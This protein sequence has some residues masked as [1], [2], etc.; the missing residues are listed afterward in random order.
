MHDLRVKPEDASNPRDQQECATGQS[1]EESVL[2]GL[3]GKFSVGIG[4]LP[5]LATRLACT[6]GG[7]VAGTDEQSPPQCAMKEPGSVQWVTHMKYGR[8]S[9]VV[10]W[11]GAHSWSCILGSHGK[12]IIMSF[13]EKRTC[14]FHREE[15]L[16]V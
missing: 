1:N 2:K 4:G 16:S 13:I 15:K 3:S 5:P 7:H 14:S 6:Q 12:N 8:V 9:N 10:N 11:M